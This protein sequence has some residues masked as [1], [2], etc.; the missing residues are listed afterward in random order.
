[1]PDARPY[2]LSAGNRVSTPYV[3]EELG[4]FTEP[5]SVHLHTATEDTELRYTLDGEEPTR[6]SPLYSEPAVVDSKL[7]LKCKAFKEG[8]ESSRT[9]GIKASPAEFLPAVASA[10]QN[11]GVRY[12]Y[13]IGNCSSVADIAS[14]KQ[15]RKGVMPK[16]SIADAD[17][18]DHFAYVFKEL[19][20]VPEKG[21][22]E[23]SVKSDDGSK[24]FIDGV[25]VVSNDYFHAA[26]AA[27]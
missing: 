16:V 18:A 24:L 14:D 4:F 13:Y 6:E 27:T 17:D 25:E 9:F 1:M 11:N 23:F 15:V 3:T 26:I 8:C 2:S 20:D 10:T 12:L 19:I 22:W 21:V 7:T 5:A